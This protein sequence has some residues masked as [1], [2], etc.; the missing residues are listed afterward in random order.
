MPHRL[1]ALVGICAWLVGWAA[2]TSATAAEHL[3]VPFSCHAH[4]GGV[5]ARPSQ[6]NSYLVVGGRE[7]A[8]FTACASDGSDRCRTM[9]L[10]RFELDCGGTR[11]GWPEFYAAISNVTTGRA[12]IEDDRLLVRVP[13]QRNRRGARSRFRPPPSRRPFLV[14]M[15]DGFAPVRGTVARFETQPSRQRTTPMQA[16]R[17]PFTSPSPPRPVAPLVQAPRRAP[18]DA[19]A[20]KPKTTIAKPQRQPDEKTTK[21]NIVAVPGEASTPKQLSDK[22]TVTK[23]TIA[24]AA[25]ANTGRKASKA[26]TTAARPEAL[27]K[28]QPKSNLKIVNA[29][30]AKA[31]PANR[32]TAPTATKAKAGSQPKNVVTAPAP[33]STPSVIPKM[34][35]GP[36]QGEAVTA[37]R[38]AAASDQSKP[39]TA[40]QPR[41][42]AD[43]L[44]KRGE[45]LRAKIETAAIQNE[46]PL[47]GASTTT[48]YRDPPSPPSLA[49]TLAVLGVVAG[50]LLTFSFAAYR[51]LTPKSAPRP[52]PRLTKSEIRNTPSL[53][54]KEPSLAGMAQ[55]TARATES[56]PV[57]PAKK[58]VPV[59]EAT[60]EPDVKPV[61][62]TA[63]KKTQPDQQSRAS[64]KI[65]EHA[66]TARGQALA[67]KTA[68]LAPDVRSLEPAVAIPQP[69]QDDADKPHPSLSLKP[70]TDGTQTAK[71]EPELPMPKLVADKIK[72]PDFDESAL[73]LPK[74]RQEALSALGVGESAGEDVIER[75]VAGLRQCWR[76]DDSNDK[77]ERKRRMQ[78]M[79]Q[80]E[81][82]WR[83]LSD[84][85]NATNEHSKHPPN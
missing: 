63:P 26:I 24:K 44:Q 76:P 77:A 60:V 16:T 68:D 22:P 31:Q 79:Q 72:K 47:G 50:L 51:L 49:N 4:A 41:T 13:P 1:V 30:S 27:P 57:R 33:K 74:T 15:P 17:D 69:T 20:A 19:P 32:P 9:M 39:Q 85:S 67:T 29:P 46:N 6:P 53:A 28:Q 42:I 61:S 73:L 80:I 66:T 62:H 83:I 48:P 8:P 82:A 84:S 40:D 34:L 10:H 37:D 45:N 81:T 36:K 59:E 43:I 12:F 70:A 71:R 64:L 5:T 21:R 58:Q 23:P 18:E 78:R 2:S 55:T 11:V 25:P 7:S 35:N 38:K 14:E 75:V 65:P 54:I 3:V 56:Q 52:Q